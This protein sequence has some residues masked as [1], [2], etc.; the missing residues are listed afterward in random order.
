MP[1][2]TPVAGIN[3]V[4]SALK[5][6]AEGV[7][8]LWLDR[9]RRDRRLSELADLAREAGIGL[10][11]L[12]RTALDQAVDGANHQGA[13]AWVRVPS[14]RGAADLADLLASSEGAPLLLVL[15]GVTDPHNLGACLRS[16]DAA[17]A[18]AVIAPRDQSVG[19]TPVVAKV[20][21]GAAET[22]PFVQV[23]N[24][25]RTL[26]WLKEQGVW[27]IG[28]AG[29][30]ESTLFQSDLRGPTALVLGSE[31]KGL[32]RLTRERCDL[33]VRLPMLGTV[34]SLNVSVAAGICLYEAVRQRLAS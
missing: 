16:A 27:V 3:S 19:L 6:G 33:L 4:R 25:A 31:G 18:Q 32:R 20:A 22:V 8:E 28:A 1:D 7:A 17:G 9:R 34:E 2:G 10:R 30:A 23:T 15:D 21:C 26:E 13:V 12:D 14:A 11:Q 24:L 5:F 29:E